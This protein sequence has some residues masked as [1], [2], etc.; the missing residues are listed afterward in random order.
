MT[1]SPASPEVRLLRRPLARRFADLRY[2]ERA[3]LVWLLVEAHR[4]GRGP[5]LV[6]S[7][8]AFVETLGI[9]WQ[10]LSRIVDRLVAAGAIAWEPGVGGLD[11]RLVVHVYADV[12]ADERSQT[13]DLARLRY[14]ALDE[15][16]DRLGF[17]AWALLVL[18]ALDAGGPIVGPATGIALRFGLTRRRLPSLARALV[19]AGAVAWHPGR[20][21]RGSA[22]RIEVL[23]HDRLVA[24]HDP[25]PLYIGIDGEDLLSSPPAVVGPWASRVERQR[26][27]AR[28]LA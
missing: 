23:D 25:K 19:G 10:R 5:A 18:V 27:Q 21:G 2:D 4:R 17:D 16:I 3:V 15:D 28:A 20:P 14:G 9:G 26:A 11:G 12:V 8:T 22:A 24:G 13:D 1:P 6:L 7:K